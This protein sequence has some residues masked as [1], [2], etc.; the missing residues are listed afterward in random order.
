MH[1]TEQEFADLLYVL[2]DAAYYSIRSNKNINAV[3]ESGLLPD[4]NSEIVYAAS[5]S[6]ELLMCLGR[7]FLLLHKS[8]Q[9]QGIPVSLPIKATKDGIEFISDGLTLSFERFNHFE[10]PVVSD[11]K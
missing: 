7:I 1:F 11:T 9:R 8:G 4:S 10:V 3:N 5:Q 6:D 2:E